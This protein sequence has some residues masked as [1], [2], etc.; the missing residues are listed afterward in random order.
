MSQQA[1]MFQS[2][3]L[4]LFSGRLDGIGR[5][6]PP[7]CKAKEKEKMKAVIEYQWKGYTPPSAAEAWDIQAQ[8]THAAEVITSTGKQLLAD[9]REELEEAGL[10]SVGACIADKYSQPGRGWF[11]RWRE[12]WRKEEMEQRDDERHY[13]RQASA[14]KT[15]RL[16]QQANA[17][18]AQALKPHEARLA[19]LAAA[20]EKRYPELNGRATQAAELVRRGH[21]AQQERS[22]RFSVCSQDGSEIYLVHTERRTC[23]CYDFKSGNAPMINN[24]PMC[25]HRAACLMWLKLQAPDPGRLSQQRQQ[26]EATTAAQRAGVLLM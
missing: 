25:K 24:A 21:V 19:R 13:R 5:E 16:W 4:P 17:A 7:D 10:R 2:E 8:I 20:A 11:P 14:A 9:L 15:K 23:T 18:R 12:I 1:N 3:D 22:A 6:T 26:F